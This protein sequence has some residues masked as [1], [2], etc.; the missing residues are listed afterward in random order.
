M[1][2]E[3]KK[4]IIIGIDGGTWKVLRPLINAGK[5][6]NLAQII[7]NGIHGDLQSTFPPSTIPAWLSMA[8]GKNPGKLGVFDFMTKNE[9]DFSGKVIHSSEFKR[10]NTYWDLL[11]RYGYRTYLINHPLLYPY[12][13]IDGV[14]VGGMGLPAY[15]NKTHV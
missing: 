5:L 12:Y 15:A 11:N 4:L 8:T 14:M 7:N 1:K 9:K 10:N 2:I 3:N 6:P 13:D